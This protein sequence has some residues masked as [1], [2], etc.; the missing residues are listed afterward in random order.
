MTWWFYQCSFLEKWCVVRSILFCFVLFW[1]PKYILK[2]TGIINHPYLINSI[3]VLFLFWF[4]DS[5]SKINVSGLRAGL[6]MRSSAF[7]WTCC[8][9]SC[10]FPASS[11]PCSLTNKVRSSP[12]KTCKMYPGGFSIPQTHL[13]LNELVIPTDTLC[14]TWWAILKRETQACTLF[15]TFSGCDM[16]E[17]NLLML[18]SHQVLSLEQMNWRHYL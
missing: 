4:E 3:E 6:E 12:R 17:V 13:S 8:S 16:M 5:F 1:P 9:M 14:L 2:G 10:L 11:L 15:L 18:E 7:T